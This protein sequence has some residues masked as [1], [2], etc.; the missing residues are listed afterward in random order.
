MRRVVCGMLVLL[1]GCAASPAARETAEPILTRDEWI[2]QYV[3][4][5]GATEGQLGLIYDAACEQLLV[6]GQRA[7]DKMEAEREGSDQWRAALGY[8]NAVNER[9]LDLEC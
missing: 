8:T 1:V 2:A 7:F 5:Y 6:I 9:M 4:T 3:R